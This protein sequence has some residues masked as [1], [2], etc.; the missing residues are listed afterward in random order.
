VGKHWDSAQFSVVAVIPLYN[1]EHYVAD[2]IDSVLAQTIK[3][4]EVIVVDDGSDDDGPAI[5]EKFESRGVQLL[6]KANGGQGSARNHG[7]A[8]STSDLICFLDQDDLWYPNHV[9]VLLHAY[10]KALKSDQ[11]RELGW[12]YSNLDEIDEQGLFVSERFLDDLGST[13]PKTSLEDCLSQD[14]FVLPGA[15]M[16]ARSAFDAA[17]GFDEKF[18]GYED[19]DLFLRI[20]RMGYRNVYVDESL[21]QWRI[22]GGSTSYSPQMAAS[23]VRYFHKLVDEYAADDEELGR[24]YVQDTIAPRFVLKAAAEYRRA[25]RR[26]DERVMDAAV[27][28]LHEVSEYLSPQRRMRV[29]AMLPV[30]RRHGLVRAATF[31]PLE[32]RILRYLS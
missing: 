22:Y 4:A 25:L 27:R 1:G 11:G 17:G 18:R 8:H 14:M 19:D 12:T 2:A 15:S 16:V 3:P 23:R 6:R 26:G 7:V 32:N 21:T 30:M 10:T 9:E 24:D 31:F 28:E 20:F 29:R 13:H 5:V